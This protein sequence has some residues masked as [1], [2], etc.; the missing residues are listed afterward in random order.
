[1]YV[2]ALS[3]TLTYTLVS[4][5]QPSHPIRAHQTLHLTQNALNA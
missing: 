4:Y 5:L 3:I 2:K 1:M